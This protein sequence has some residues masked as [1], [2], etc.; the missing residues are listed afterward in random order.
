MLAADELERLHT[1]L[2]FIDLVLLDIDEI[3][4]ISIDDLVRAARS[5]VR[6]VTS[7]GLR[8][9]AEA[10]NLYKAM[11]ITIAGFSK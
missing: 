8:P 9:S 7:H 6:S 10:E 4:D 2:V 3:D 11:Q 5:Y 1:A